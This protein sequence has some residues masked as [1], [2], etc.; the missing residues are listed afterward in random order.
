MGLSLQEIYFNDNRYGARIVM[1]IPLLRLL[2][3]I[4]TTR[5]AVYIIF[6]V[7]PRFTWLLMILLMVFYLYGVFGVTMIGEAL[8][9]L[10]TKPDYKFDSFWSAVIAL[11]QLTVGEGW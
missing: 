9:D 3:L 11:F 6:Q 10:P 8:N 7:I 4:K 2:T 5:S 1:V